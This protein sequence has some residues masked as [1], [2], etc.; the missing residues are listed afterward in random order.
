[1]LLLPDFC[2]RTARGVDCRRVGLELLD[3][4]PDRAAGAGDCRGGAL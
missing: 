2:E 1:M 4:D 3:D